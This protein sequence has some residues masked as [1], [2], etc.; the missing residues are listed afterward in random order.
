MGPC[1]FGF[2]YGRHCHFGC[3]CHSQ[4][5]YGMAWARRSG[6]R[7]RDPGAVDAGVAAIVFNSGMTQERTVTRRRSGL[8]TERL[9]LIGVG[10][11]I[12]AVALYETSLKTYG[13]GLMLRLSGL[14]LS[15]V[16][17][18]VLAVWAA[19]RPETGARKSGA[20]ALTCAIISLLAA[21]A[22]YLIGQAIQAALDVAVVGPAAILTMALV[23]FGVIA[24]VAGVI[25]RINA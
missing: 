23:V 17:G 2:G 14:F 6:Q 10:I 1:S 24:L 16:G 3:C 12:L 18:V 15:V 13:D 8:W 20:F 25:K 11:T 19:R 9:F 22:T 7:V 21:G 5:I 4:Q